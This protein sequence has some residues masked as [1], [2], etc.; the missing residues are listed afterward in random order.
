MPPLV[1]VSRKLPADALAPLAEVARL[2]VWREEEAAIPRSELLARSRDADGLLVL[3]T[4]RVDG[5]LLAAAP[6]LRAV[7]TMAVGFDHIDVGACTARG[8]PVCNTPDVLTETTADLCWAILMACAR[9]IPEG[10]AAIGAGRWR[11]WAPFFMAGQDIHGKTLGIVGMGRIGHAVARR[12]HGF[13]MRILYAG[14]HPKPDVDQETGAHHVSLETLLADADFVVLL[15]PLTAA[16]RHLI[17]REELARMRPHAIL[18]NAGRGGLCDQ[19][20]LVDALRARRIWGAALDVFEQEPL[21][22]D[23]ALLDLPHVVAVPHIGSASVDTRQAM[24]RLAA[25]NLAQVLRGERPAYCV[26][27]EVFGGTSAA[28]GGRPGEH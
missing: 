7:S 17:G 24:A 19:D 9:R 8:I 12:A 4:D 23:H 27:P 21:P 22:P 20:A 18:V 11:D 25:A 1:F 6:G 3:L 14:P 13:G 28:G 5:A 15:A 10:Q 2:E 16:T 26:N